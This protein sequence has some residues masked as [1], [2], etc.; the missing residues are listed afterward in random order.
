M[1]IAA[2]VFIGASLTGRGTR[3]AIGEAKQADSAE[4]GIEYYDA[5]AG[6]VVVL[7][8]S[9]ARPASDFNELATAL[10]GADFRTLA[11]ESRGIGASEGGGPRSRPTLFD[12]AADVGAVLRASGVADDTPVHVVGHAFGNR[13]AR[14]FATRYPKRTRRVALIAAG[15]RAPIPEYLTRA[16][17]ISAATFLPWSWREPSLR[18]AFFASGS[19]IPDY[20]KTG[21][22]LWG[23][24]AQGFAARAAK[25]EEFWAGG[26]GTLLALQAM[27]DALAPALVS[28]FVLRDEFPRRVKLVPV[29]EA[30]HA[31]LPEQPKAIANEIIAF[32]RAAS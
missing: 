8:A 1:L 18:L 32:L 9:F 25:S 10:H 15:G 7:L 19:E 5:G 24:L 21:W 14:S 17:M 27:D 28:G 3:A 16:I 20:W 4:L 23:G 30:G 13:V 6:D 12:L 29:T 11:I 26:S 31:F 22:S 2:L